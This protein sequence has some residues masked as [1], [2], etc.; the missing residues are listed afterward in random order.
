[1]HLSGGRSPADLIPD[2][3][4]RV[5]DV[6]TNRPAIIILETFANLIHAIHK[7]RGDAGCLRAFL[8]GIARNV[9]R[10]DWRRKKLAALSEGELSR[11]TDPRPSSLQQA[12]GRQELER[13]MEAIDQ[14]DE[15]ARQILLLR[16][17]EELPLSEVASVMELPL[18]T[19]KSHIHRCRK[20]LRRLLENE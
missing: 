8:F 16:F 2:T 1:M 4:I 11:L 14:L 9:M 3:V 15:P 20:R 19:V 7:M 17:V 5:E 18:G 12:A 13:A 10:K 6:F